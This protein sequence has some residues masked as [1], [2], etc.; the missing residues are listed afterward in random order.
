MNDSNH[1]NGRKDTNFL[2]LNAAELSILTNKEFFLLKRNSIDKIVASFAQLELLI[3]DR[4]QYL[5]RTGLIA[6]FRKRGNI[7]KGENYLGLPY[8]VLD[9]PAVFGKNGVHAYRTMFWWGNSWSIT[10][11]IS[12][13]H[14]NQLPSS[15]F[16]SVV[17]LCPD[18]YL[19]GI[20]KGEWDH[21]FGE[22]N[23]VPFS[24]VNISPV[25]LQSAAAEKGFLKIADRWPM[26]QINETP[27]KVSQFLTV[28]TTLFQKS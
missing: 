28:F 7:T 27:E 24:K 1:N 25:Q 23:F 12:G 21:H 26:E 14:L 6:D 18:H 4:F 11:H 10:F 2:N 16:E 5:H 3:N 15:F 20:G 22:D 9:H 17:S 19:L 13:N 8:V